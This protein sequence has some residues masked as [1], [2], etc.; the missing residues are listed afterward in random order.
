MKL[1]GAAHLPASRQIERGIRNDPVEPGTKCLTGIEPI[2]RLIRANESILYR[3]LSVFMDGDDSP[4]HEVRASLVQAHQA[5]EGVMI[6]SAG[7][8]SQR[9]FLM[10]NTCRI[11]QS[12]SVCRR[13]DESYGVTPITP[14]WRPVLGSGV[15]VRRKPGAA[16]L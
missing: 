10:G 16:S 8:F 4:S 3:V 7:S 13:A 11:V 1:F 12:L 2:E 14:S 6:A 9:A 15:A 5:R